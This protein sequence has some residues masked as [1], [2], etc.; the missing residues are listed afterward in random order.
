MRFTACFGVVF[1]IFSFSASAT[2]IDEARVLLGKG[3]PK[4]CMELLETQFDVMAENVEF[5]Y[6]LGISS[7][8]AGRPG[9]AV[10]AFERVLALDSN[11]VQARAEL[12][13]AMIALGD[14]ESAKVE[15]MQVR[16][17]NLPPEVSTRIDGLLALVQQP[18][19]SQSGIFSAYVETDFGY[20]S[21]INT[22]TDS[23]SVFIPLING[24]ATLSG[25]ATEQSS[26][27]LGLNGGVFTQKTV[28]RG[29]DVYGNLDAR[30]R[31]HTNQDDFHTGALSG[32]VGVKFSRGVDQYSLG[33]TKYV[34]FINREKND[35]QISIYGQWQR[36]ISRQD[37]FG[38]FGQ[39]V[40]AEHP[41]A[42]F[43]D[44]NL[45]LGGA[46]WTHAFASTGDPVLRMTLFAG[47]DRERGDDESVGR[48]L[49]GIKANVDYSLRGNLKAF[50]GVAA[51]VS[52]YGDE[53]IFFQKT[54]NDER[55][56]INAGLAYKPSKEWTLSGQVIYLRNDS[57]ISI[58][59][60][61][62]R[63]A[64]VTLRR[65]FF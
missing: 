15:L 9:K 52:H 26:S 8:D 14:Y 23:T 24:A 18:R 10:F 48:H 27:L 33:L 42:T 5:N 4:E 3:Q 22:A 36:Q 51:Q 60:Y 31:Y 12:G 40:R 61:D 49:G 32:G 20:D 34:Y 54:R 35:D 30:L 39:Y 45:Y 29:V 38:I 58:Y 19:A 65:D 46:T 53:N 55:Y 56:D 17:T 1:L 6:L 44:T 63:Q 41:I 7:L 2:V 16:A 50:G 21:N 28:G 11:H 59:D 13:R 62:R 37:I 25:L 57:N 64:L 47:D 43:L